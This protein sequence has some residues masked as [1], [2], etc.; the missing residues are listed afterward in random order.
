MISIPSCLQNILCLP[1]SVVIQLCVILLKMK[2]YICVH[3]S[4]QGNV[5]YSTKLLYLI[6]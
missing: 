3:S 4:L 2:V 6:P 1:V 5:V